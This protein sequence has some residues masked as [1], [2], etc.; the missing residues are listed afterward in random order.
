[1][2]IDCDGEWGLDVFIN[3]QQDLGGLFFRVP[4]LKHNCRDYERMFKFGF[5]FFARKFVGQILLER[6]KRQWDSG[7]PSLLFTEGGG[8]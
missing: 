8:G 5:I 4:H 6:V 2:L 7:A 1:M 3:L